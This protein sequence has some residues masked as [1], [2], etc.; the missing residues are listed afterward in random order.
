MGTVLVVEDSLGVRPLIV[1]ILQDAGF[2]VLEAG[3]AAE[4]LQIASRADVVLSDITL[5]D[6]SGLDLAKHLLGQRPGLK[7]LFMS[8]FD[9]SLPQGFEFIEKPFQPEELVTRIKSLL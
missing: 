9:V 8:G 7:I 6:G 4:A 5:P 2:T 1:R 3:S